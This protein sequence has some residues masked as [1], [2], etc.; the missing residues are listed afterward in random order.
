MRS[1]SLKQIRLI[2][3]LPCGCGSGAGCCGWGCVDVGTC[4]LE[5]DNVGRDSVDAIVFFF[6]LPRLLMK[7]RISEVRRI[8][9]KSDNTKQTLF[10]VL[11]WVVMEPVQVVVQG[12]E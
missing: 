10:L 4:S 6:G 1:V 5:A 7:R 9:I 3:R 12:R 11:L 8:G 2:E